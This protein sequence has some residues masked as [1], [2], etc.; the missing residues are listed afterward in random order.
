[1]HSRP[2]SVRGMLCCKYV[3]ITSNRKR[4][5]CTAKGLITITRRYGLNSDTICGILCSLKFF[6]QYAI[7]E[8]ARVTIRSVIVMAAYRLT[9]TVTAIVVIIYVNFIS[10]IELS[11]V[12]TWNSVPSYVP[13]YTLNCYAPARR[14]GAISVAFVRPSVCMSVRRVHSE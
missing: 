1:M 11:T 9:L 10:L 12:N 2:I 5:H 3:E 8:T 4:L 6:G 13:S 14:E 7:S